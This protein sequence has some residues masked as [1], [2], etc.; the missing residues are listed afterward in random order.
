MDQKGSIEEGQTE[1]PI[2]AFS[3]PDLA[4]LCSQPLIARCPPVIFTLN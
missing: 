3:S 4:M 1:D 2:I